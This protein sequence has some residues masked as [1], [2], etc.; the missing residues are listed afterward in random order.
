MEVVDGQNS[1]VACLRKQTLV[2]SLALSFHSFLYSFPPQFESASL[3][4]AFQ[5]PRAPARVCCS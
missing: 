3:E 4:F 5:S 2:I 1:D